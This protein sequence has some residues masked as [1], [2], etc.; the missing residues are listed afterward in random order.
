MRIGVVTFPGSLDDVDARSLG[1]SDAG[2]AVTGRAFDFVE[3]P[4]LG[5][6]FKAVVKFF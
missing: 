6:V 2:S 1:G 5:L 4:R 3:L